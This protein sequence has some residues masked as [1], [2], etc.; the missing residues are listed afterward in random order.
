LVPESSG[1]TWLRGVK[2]AF[3]H[4]HSYYKRL[5]EEIGHLLIVHSELSVLVTYPPLGKHET[6]KHM[7]GFHALVKGSPRRAEHNAKENF[8]MIFGYENP[9]GWKG[10]VYNDDGWKQIGGI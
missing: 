4:E 1:G 10:L 6:L 8:L 3:E 7:G 5:Y 9:W 2:I